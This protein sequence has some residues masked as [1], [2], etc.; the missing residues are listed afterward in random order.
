MKAPDQATVDA[1][2][3]AKLAAR[4]S[5]ATTVSISEPVVPEEN[6]FDPAVIDARYRAKMAA[7]RKA[8]EAPALPVPAAKAKVKSDDS[9]RELEALEAAESERLQK[10]ALACTACVVADGRVVKPCLDHFVKAG[11]K[12]EQYESF[13]AQLAP[14]GTAHPATT[15]AEHVKTGAV[16]ETKTKTETG[17]AKPTQRR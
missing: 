1:R 13:V 11:Y 2:Y 7:R 10:E 3:Q 14:S 6:P 8:A 9:R 15:G 16:D 4:A 17:A 12:A 5:G